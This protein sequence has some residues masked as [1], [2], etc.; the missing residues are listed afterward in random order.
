MTTC[1]F[2]VSSLP[3]MMCVVVWFSL[4]FP[5]PAPAWTLTAPHVGCCLFRA[6]RVG[7][8]RQGFACVGA[9]WSL[10][11]S[12]SWKQMETGGQPLERDRKHGG[13]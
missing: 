6:L 7:P 13:G 5:Q 8:C 9:V 1:L 4:L 11:L 2:R 12:R 10:A 3:S